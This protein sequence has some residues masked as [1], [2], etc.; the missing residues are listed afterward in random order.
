MLQKT[1]TL[2]GKSFEVRDEDLKFYEKISPVFNGKTCL[3]PPPILHPKERERR[4]LAFRNERNLYNR[5]SSLSGKDIISNIHPSSPYNVYSHDEWWSDKW[6]ALDYGRDF[7]FKRPFFEQFHELLYQ[8]PRPPLINNKAENSDY[9]NYADGNKN[10]YLI[11]TSNWNEDSY[12][13]FLLVNNEN[14]V[15]CLWC[16]DCEL[17]YQCIDCVKCY[18]VKYA[19]NCEQCVESSFLMDCMGLENCMFCINL[20]KKKYHI[21]NK[22]FPKEEYE[23]RVREI[24]GSY[25]E[26]QKMLAQFKQLRKDHSI[27]RASN[28]VNSENVS[29]NHI[30]NSKNIYRGFD[31]YD[32]RDCAYVHDGLKG[33]DC[34]DVDYFDGTELC[35]ESTSLIGYGYRFTAFCRDSYNLFYCDNCHSCKNCFGC[36]GLRNEQYCILNRKYSQEEYERLIPIIIKHMSSPSPLYYEGEWGEFFPINLSCFAYNETL[37]YDEFP[38]T[39][40]EALNRN[41]M[42]REPDQHEYRPQNIKISDKVQEVP[43]T[44]TSNIL[45][46]EDCGKNYRIIPQ[47]FK[48]YR[49]MKVPVP[50]K[51]PDCRHINRIKQR[52]PRSL[53]NRSCSKCKKSIQTSYSPDRPETIYCEKCYLE[54]VY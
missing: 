2:T 31:I 54:A 39:R 5:K 35:Y 23:K 50:H 26:F 37:A 44:I 30:F 28:I 15:D 49:H 7:D 9:C 27:R 12:Y 51:C 20:R 4:R 17:V 19:Q 42:W 21:F 47:E 25:S 46:C 11:T 43:D 14:A 32:C 13:G 52:N 29:G 8:V 22:P 1:C 18:N 33:V 10:C 38:L 41:Y 48:Y 36:T 34:Y 24:T 3:I 53:F 40:E 16:T 6:D 45:A